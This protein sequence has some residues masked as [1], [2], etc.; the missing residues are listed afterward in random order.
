MIWVDAQD[1][2]YVVF[3]DGGVPT[4]AQYPDNFRE[5]DQE[6]DETLVPPPGLLQPVRGFGLIW[7]GNPRVR[8]RLGWAT[9]PEVAFEGMVQADSIELSVATLY[10]RA[11][12]GGILALNA[13]DDDWEMLPPSTASP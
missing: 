11:R 12:D 6:S 13:L 2:I 10:L 5:G 3:D 4:W 9:T 8:D 7:R 1:R